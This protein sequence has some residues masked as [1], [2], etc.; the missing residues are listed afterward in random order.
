[1]RAGAGLDPERSGG[2][3][4]IVAAPG[5]LIADL[6]ARGLI[7]DST[8]RDALRTRLEAGP[9]TVY[10]GFDPTGESLHVGHL[11]G[12][13]GLRRFLDAG[14]RAI[15]LAG[16]A[17]GMVGDP[18]GRS[19]ERN[20][21]D[22]DR[23]AHNLAS[24][25]AQ[26]RQVL[27]GVDGWELLDNAVWTRPI[28]VL[29]FLR[30]VGKHVTVNQMV[31]KESVRARMAGDSGISF[32]EFS[33]MLLQAHDY[34]WLHTHHGCDLQIGGSDQWGNITTGIDLIRRRGGGP[35]HGLTWP[36]LLRSDGSKFGKSATGDNV[37]LDASLTSPYRFYQYWLQAAD[38]V[39]ER[40]LLQ[41]TLVAV[42]EIRDLCARHR[43][44]PGHRLAQ[45]R[46]AAELTGIVHGDGA[47]ETAVAASRLLFGGSALEATTETLR[48]LEDEIPT[49][50]L[51]REELDEPVPVA[52]LLVRSGL[53]TSAK[54]ARRTID[55]GGGYC[56]DRRVSAEDHVTPDDL[57][58]GRHVLLRKG[59]KA[60][61]LVVVGEA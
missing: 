14:H 22:D 5:D 59:R 26:I 32:T 37:W 17:T 9:V 1:M 11:L 61:A 39:V 53:A 13:L 38:D 30:D 7:H 4:W 34:W 25:G 50:R 54:D 48:T 51:T 45:T 8:D 19:D 46:L 55:Q 33:Y 52:D 6:E 16:G 28:G 15:A 60:Y 24:I 42:D 3:D 35:V 40:L 41:L 12:L 43:A 58:H 21:L 29:E 49:L 47:V 27:G 31:A 23:L 2:D 56:N 44:G 20:L 57:L 18:S 36:L 10:C